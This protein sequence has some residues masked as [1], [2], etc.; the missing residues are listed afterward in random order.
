MTV[1]LSR[2][3]PFKFLVSR[4]PLQLLCTKQLPSYHHFPITGTPLV[5]LAPRG[6]GEVSRPVP[7]GLI[8]VFCVLASL[9]RRFSPEGGG[10][11]SCEERPWSPR[12]SRTC[13]FLLM[14]GAPSRYSLLP[15]PYPGSVPDQ[16]VPKV[17]REAM[18]GDDPAMSP[19]PGTQ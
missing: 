9:H 15:S 2:L 14:V 12:L 11:T 8:P 6:S 10:W 13:F 4:C 3:L 18:A 16:G 17:P 5:S 19:G 7:R 1:C